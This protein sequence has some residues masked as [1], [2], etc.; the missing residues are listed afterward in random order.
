MKVKTYIVSNSEMHINTQF[1]NTLT[2]YTKSIILTKRSLLLP[3]DYDKSILLFTKQ[4]HIMNR[5]TFIRRQ[6]PL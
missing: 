4:L 5:I 3:V 2:D 6:E 1:K